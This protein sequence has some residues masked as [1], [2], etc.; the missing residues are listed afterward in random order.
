M[1]L[2]ERAG[3]LRT[4]N[5]YLDE[6]E[7]G[8]GRLVFVSG[9]AGI[10]KT[11]LVGALMESAKDRARVMVA[12]SDGSATPAPL[13]PLRE[14]LPGLP[15]GVWPAEDVHEAAAARSM[16]LIPQ[17][18]SRQDLFGRLL[19]ALRDPAGPGGPGP[20]L[21]VIEDAHHADQATLDLLLFIARRVHTCRALVVVTYRDENLDTTQGLRLL[22]GD[23]ASATGTRRLGVPALSPQAVADLVVA[24]H[25]GDEPGAVDA[26]RLHEITRGNAFY[27]T[28][29]LS[30]GMDAIPD[31]CRDA[32]LARV[33]G[34]SA[35]ATQALEIVALAGARVDVDVLEELLSDGLRALDEAL[36]RGLLVETQGVITFRHE[37]ARLV[38]E[39]HVAPGKR[40]HQ[41]RRL[42]AALESRGADPAR[43]AHHAD[44]GDLSHE[45]VDHATAA[46]MEASALGAHREAARQF[47]RAL[48]HARRLPPP[49]LPEARLA[50]L[51]WA[52]GY[53]L[54]ITGRT[55]EAADAVDSA[56]EIWERLGSTVRV[57][58]AWRCLSRLLWFE[59]RTANAH[60]AGVRALEVLEGV[61]APTPQ[62][63]YAYGNMTQLQLLSG[64]GVSTREWGAKTL[65][66]IDALADD[67]ARTE[68]RSNALTSLGTMEVV[69]GDARRGIA[70]LEESLDMA[71]GSELH[72]HAARAYVNL[73][74]T[75]LSQR[76]IADARRHVTEGLEYCTER[77]LDT[78][79]HGLLE[80][81]ADLCLMQGDLDGTETRAQ[82]LLDQ[83]SLP[84]LHALDPL[85]LLAHVHGRRRSGE[86]QALVERAVALAE[87]TGEMQMIAPVTELRCEL[88]WIA[89]RDDEAAALA[90]ESVDL[91]E[92]ADCRWN[93]GGVLR[94]LN[95]E[96]LTATH[97]E[98]APPF[99]AELAGRSREAAAL[100]EELGCP[101][102]QGLALARGGDPEDLVEAIGI[103]DGMKAFGASERCRADLRSQGHA[104]PRAPRQTTRDHPLGLTAREAEVAALVAQGL[105][106]SDIAERLSISRRTAEHHVSS[107]LLKLG[108][109]SRRELD[110][111][112]AP[113]T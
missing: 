20:Y 16:W 43:L 45:T 36:A 13:A 7:A 106:D 61:G 75:A 57:G 24:E 108:A 87:E 95:P 21:I 34:L 28:E 102:D 23:S 104:A 91:V 41:H 72:E 12:Y 99:A 100:W 56:R 96:S 58:D 31:Q 53:E 18:P 29:V 82:A 81:D 59:G 113:L 90:L 2:V 52:L 26:A 55:A 74:S 103:F 4:L 10:G 8:H 42:Y 3:Q 83:P 89:G 111:R 39:E 11:A 112:L 22:I 101:F 50:D 86:T 66:L 109:T 38:V 30:S 32:I 92:T 79:T 49:G 63:A 6:A 73:A 64:D 17:G 110:E 94:W 93:R 51:F 15:P 27:V 5:A 19:A 14:L 71:R 25:P 88:A 98:V 62:L 70:M 69:D 84:R 48:R 46:G 37:L 78:W 47:Q 35:G 97:R 33:A 85:V 105:S 9:E 68:L 65:E 44:A 60:R 76:R 67:P 54:Y 40:I 77:D 1:M 107:I 80:A